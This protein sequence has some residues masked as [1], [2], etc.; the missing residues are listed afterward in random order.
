MKLFMG[1]RPEAGVPVGTSQLRRPYVGVPVCAE[2]CH[3]N[4]DCDNVAYNWVCDADISAGIDNHCQGSERWAG[5]LQIIAFTKD[6]A[7]MTPLAA[8][9]PSGL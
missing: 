8:I 2:G 7:A 4:E 3:E 6:K 1:D 9:Q 5:C